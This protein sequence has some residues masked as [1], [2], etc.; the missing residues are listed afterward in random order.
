MWIEFNFSEDFGGSFFGV[1][2]FIEVGFL[3]KWFEFEI[4]GVYWVLIVL[5]VLDLLLL[6]CLDFLLM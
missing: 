1:V 2:G 6:N 4:R 5:W 3:G